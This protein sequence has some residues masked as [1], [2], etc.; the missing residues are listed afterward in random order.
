MSDVAAPRNSTITLQVM[1]NRLLA[2]VEEQAQALIRTAFSPIVRECGDIS[3]GIFDVEGRMLA[4]AVTGTPGHVNTMAEGAKHFLA[5]FPADAM[6]AGDIY[7]TN[8]PWLATGHLNDLLLLAP[9]FRGGDLV[10]LV[11]CT[12]HLYDLGGVGMGPDG[13]DVFDEGLLIPMVKL[14][15]EGWIND[16]LLA[17][18][19]ANSRA[20]VS[21][22]GD[23][24]ALISCCEVGARR[25]VEMMDE[26]G[27]ERLDPLA[28]Y[29][30]EISR[31]GTLETIRAVP[32]GVYTNEMRLDGYESEIELRVA[33]SVSEDGML[34][35]FSG[36]SPCSQRGIN[37]PINYTA[38]YTTFGLRCII[39]PGIPNNAGSLEPFRVTAP[40]GTILSAPRPAPVAMRHII[41]HFTSDLVLGC[42]HRA[43]PR[44]VP[45]ESCSVMWDL[46]IRNGSIVLPHEE[47]SA[48][49][50][51]L[52]HHG[53]MGARPTKDG[54]S[55]TAFPS[56]VWGSQVEITES[57]VPVRI[58]RRELRPDTGGAGRFRGGL[59]QIIELE[60]ADRSPISLFAAVDR[61]EH[62]ARGR[63]GGATGACGRITLSSGRK[64]AG[65]GMQTIPADERLIFETPGGGGYGEARER[66]SERVAADVRAGLVSREAALR[67]Y[68]VE[69]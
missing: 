12:S 1:W 34:A 63:A 19:K 28:D 41:G 27:L 53:G 7:A 39:A 26:F 42:L 56:G 50:I 8:D 2:V 67:D 69:L 62:P 9:V 59:G 31:G 14:V 6:R 51:E 3:A 37:V 61:I 29:I 65:K 49:A 52:T 32:R 60:S 54:L 17:L 35:D 22:E 23:V 36:S 33:L 64:L 25:L 10:G 68:G 58:L 11:S 13:S 48:F 38:A 66:D 21:N 47:R 44:S 16:L 46:P 30:C 55:A 20:P 45:A 18:I 24:Y 40:P 15:D 5:A 43:M 57:V 4:Q